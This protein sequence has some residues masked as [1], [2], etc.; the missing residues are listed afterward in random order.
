MLKLT[1]IILN[2][3]KRLKK[4]ESFKLLILSGFQKCVSMCELKINE[5]LFK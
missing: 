3:K 5:S 1:E 2:E 4:N